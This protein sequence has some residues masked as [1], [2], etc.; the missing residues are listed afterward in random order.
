MLF[1]GALVVLPVALILADAGSALGGTGRARLVFLWSGPAAAG[2]LAAAIFPKPAADPSKGFSAKAALWLLPFCAVAFLLDN[3]AVGIGHF[4][5]WVT[6]TFGDQWLYDHLPTSWA[7][8]LPVTL[9]LGILGWE[10]ALRRALLAAWAQR[11]RLPAAAAISCGVGIALS[12]PAV[13]GGPAGSELP[14]TASAILA[15]ASREVGSVLIFLS[16][17]GILLAGAWRG[18]FLYV[19]AL[20]LGDWA[21]P[22]FPAANY[23]SSDPRFYLLRGAMAVLAAGVVAIGARRAAR[24]P[25]LAPAGAAP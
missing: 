10:R 2:L 12:L 5:G 24:G 19:D 22:A 17:G 15:A 14:F 16:G 7:W 18:T 3:I 4:T 21:G 9:A 8:G 23:A 11:V 25:G 6:F 1:T 20:V 13:L